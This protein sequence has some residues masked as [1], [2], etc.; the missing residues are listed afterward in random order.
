MVTSTSSIHITDTMNDRNILNE[1]G[2]NCLGNCTDM[3]LK[4]SFKIYLIRI[5][6]FNLMHFCNNGETIHFLVIHLLAQIY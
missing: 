2:D 4:N 5:D 6:T 3:A 1:L